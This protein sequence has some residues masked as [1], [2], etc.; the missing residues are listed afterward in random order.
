[1]SEKIL[2]G[3]VL[4]V[5]GSKSMVLSEDNR[6]F[7]ILDRVDDYVGEKIKFDFDK[8]LLMP[9]YLYAVAAMA[10]DDLSGTLDSIKENWFKSL[11]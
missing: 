10:E 9:S 4:S 8:V 11:K 5:K 1:M 2:N 6:Y 7:V 3:T